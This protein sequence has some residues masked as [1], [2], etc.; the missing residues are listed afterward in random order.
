[1][2]ETLDDVF[3][4]AMDASSAF[5]L[6]KEL[7]DGHV[8]ENVSFGKLMIEKAEFKEKDDN[9]MLHVQ[10]D[11]DAEFWAIK[12]KDNKQI[13]ALK[14]EGEYFYY[15]VTGDMDKQLTLVAQD[16]MVATLKANNLSDNHF[17]L[18]NFI[19]ST[20]DGKQT[21]ISSHIV[22]K[23]NGI[24]TKTEVVIDDEKVVQTNYSVSAKGDI[25]VSGYGMTGAVE[26]KSKILSDGEKTTGAFFESKVLSGTTIVDNEIWHCE[27]GKLSLVGV[28]KD[29]TPEKNTKSLQIG[30]K[31]VSY[32][33]VSEMP[34]DELSYVSTL[35]ESHEKEI[36]ETLGGMHATVEDI[37]CG[38]R[39]KD[40]EKSA[41]KQDLKAQS[42]EK[43]TG[44]DGNPI[45]IA[46]QD[47]LKLR[48]A[49][50]EQRRATEKTSTKTTTSRSEV[51]VNLLAQMER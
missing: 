30:G 28:V 35:S 37:L 42:L 9:K 18:D 50:R 22:M 51:S 12:T 29:E 23:D 47:R 15:A 40:A 7:Q 20:E 38:N 4:T 27:D 6:M 46:R 5:S 45:T 48:L 43:T 36:L 11:E 14:T 25:N 44:F 32:Q 21:D 31:K 3:E 8:E 33:P 19:Q 16:D 34:A 39:L 17:I 26:G 41:L 1:M 13:L 24:S 2:S 10:V 49:S